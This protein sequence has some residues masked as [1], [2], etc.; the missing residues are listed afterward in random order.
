MQ[1]IAADNGRD[2]GKFITGNKRLVIPSIIG[3]YRERKISEGGEYEV[4]VDGQRC[5][6][7]ELAHQ[8]SRFKRE[9]VS[10]SKIHEETKTL[11]L[12]AIAL[13]AQ[14]D[15]IN[16]ITGLPVEQHKPA[17]K[18]SYIDLLSGRHRVKINGRVV[19]F[20][21]NDMAV[22][23]EGAGAYW[24]AV[25]NLSRSELMRGNVRLIDIGSR[26][27]NALT[28]SGKRFVDL[29]SFTLNYG[30]IEVKNAGGDDL[31]CEQFVRRIVADISGH[32]LDFENDLILL[33]GGGALLLENDLKKIF[34]KA[35]IINEPVYA[36]ALGFYSMGCQKWQGK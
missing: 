18:Q 19:D 1:T 7:G 17:I 15:H 5:F 22:S 33:T 28:I 20:V 16:L 24:H 35:Q 12:S 8:E 32:W 23:I 3:E 10:R 13:L 34:K 30:C 21:I 36:N 31:V 2:T 26:T 25:L 11:T 14:D 27:I 6:I 4:E 9:N 29:D